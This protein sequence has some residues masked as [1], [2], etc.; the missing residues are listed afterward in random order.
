MSKLDSKLLTV[1]PAPM[2]LD[3]LLVQT[4]SLFEADARKDDV[5]LRIVRQPSLDE[6]I[7]GQDVVADSGRLSQVSSNT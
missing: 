1:A 2:N 5:L 6:L 4:S 3:D 7:A